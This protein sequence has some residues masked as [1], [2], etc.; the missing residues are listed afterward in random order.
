MLAPAA[1]R[2]GIPMREQDKGIYYGVRDGKNG[3]RFVN[4]TG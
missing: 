1:V 2:L 4:F 3:E